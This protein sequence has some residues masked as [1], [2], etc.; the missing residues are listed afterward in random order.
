MR[1]LI[2]WLMELLNQGDKEIYNG[3]MLRIMQ[4]EGI[5]TTIIINN[6]GVLHSKVKDVLLA[7]IENIIKLTKK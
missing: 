7:E 2:L 3:P 4:D 6:R 5:I 1:E